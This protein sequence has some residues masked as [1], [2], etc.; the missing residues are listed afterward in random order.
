MSTD[1]EAALRKGVMQTLS[2]ETFLRYIDPEA[3]PTGVYAPG[4]VGLYDGILPSEPDTAVMVN[5]YSVQMI[6]VPIIGIQFHFAALDPDALSNAVQAVSDVFEGRWGG[7]L[8]SVRLVSA[9]W[10]SGTPLGQDANG[11][12]G[13][14]E[15]YYLTISRTIP[16]RTGE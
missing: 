15:N 9:A 10:Q 16:R 1:Y 11:R 8:G 14:T 4:D 6:P 2:D 12:R 5:S 7:T 13:R 3:D